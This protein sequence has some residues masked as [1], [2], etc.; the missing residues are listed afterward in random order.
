VEAFAAS[1]PFAVRCET[2]DRRLG[3]TRNFDRAIAR[4][5][6]DVIALAD[7]DDVWKPAKLERLAGELAAA[8]DVGL[9]FSDA[10]LADETLRPLNRRL[11]TVV[12]GR[13]A[14][15]ALARPERALGLLL[16]GWTV[17]GATLAFRARFRPLVLPIP[18]DL[19]MIH[20]GWIALV[21]SSV[22]RVR[23]I[24]EPLMWYRQHAGQQVGARA[25]RIADPSVAAALRRATSYGETLRT[26]AELRRRLDGQSPGMPAS[27]AGLELER[28]AR[29]LEIR[30]TLPAS[31]LAR[32]AVVS[33]E[34]VALRYHRYGRG[35]N[36]AA[37]DL[38]IGPR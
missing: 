17:A 32:L 5:T 24:D 38:V 6:G 21:V 27:R 30:R 28:L 19:A 34:L 10:E 2:T 8:S 20:D 25:P 36:S 9:V 31:W 35:L 22:A 16:P 26:I 4:C 1:A 11:W 14:R 29:H 37:K 23:F 13:H 33:R 18:T 12:G 7:Q 3:S 15:R